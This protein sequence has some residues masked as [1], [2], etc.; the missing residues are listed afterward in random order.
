MVAVESNYR[1]RDRDLGFNLVAHDGMALLLLYYP[2]DRARYLQLL[3]C[4]CL[5]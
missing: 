3:G 2:G 5:G 4:L 1:R